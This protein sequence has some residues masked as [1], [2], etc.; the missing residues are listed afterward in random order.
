M[1]LAAVY[2][3]EGAASG[4]QA[5]AL[6]LERRYGQQGRASFARVGD[7]RGPFAHKGTELVGVVNGLV[8]VLL[9]SGRPVLRR[10]KT[11]LASRRGID[12]WRNRARAT[13]S[14]CGFCGTEPSG[15]PG[16]CPRWSSRAACFAG[17]LVVA[18]GVEGELAEE[19]AGG[20]DDADVGVL[21]E[22]Q[23]VGPADADVV[24]AAAVTQ[25]DGAVGV[26]DVGANA[27]VGVGGGSPGVA[28]GRAW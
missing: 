14:A 22:E 19:F 4:S 7:R 27:V 9:S 12:G 18:G 5:D 25:G 24:E 28:L 13:R 1:L 16:G 2:H 17:G 23:D 10:G 8:Q 20:V 11:L 6:S 21:G 3:M 26:D 15:D